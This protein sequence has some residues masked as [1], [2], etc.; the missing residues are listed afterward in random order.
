MAK[1]IKTGGRK[2]GTPN[3]AGSNAVLAMIIAKL[4]CDPL[5]AL[6]EIAANKREVQPGLRAAMF[7]AAVGDVGMEWRGRHRAQMTGCGLARAKDR[8]DG[9]KTSAGGYCAERLTGRD[10]CQGPGLPW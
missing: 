5:E 1:G 6:A 2:A 9:G 8:E 10:Q 4:G 3:K 7:P